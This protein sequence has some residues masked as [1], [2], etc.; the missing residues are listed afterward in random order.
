MELN[1]IDIKQLH[2][3][4][5]IAEEGSITKAAE[6]IHMAQ[7]PL[8]KQLKMLE[9]EL[10]VEL[11]ERNT[12]NLKITEAGKHLHYRAQ[13]I[14]DL[15]ETT[16]RELKDYDEGIYGTLT[17]GTIS[18]AGDTL[19]PEKVL[20][21]HKKYPNIRFH[22]KKNNTH[23]VLDLLKNGLIDVGI[24][25]TPIDSEYYDSI[26]FPEEPMVAATVGTPFWTDSQQA[27]TIADLEGKPLLILNRYKETVVKACHNA[28]FEP[29]IIGKIDDTR[30]IMLWANK[31]MGVAIVQRDWPDLMG[32][33]D[34][35]Y[36]EIAE[37]LL[38]TQPAVVWMKNRYLS[39]VTRHF[40]ES[41]TTE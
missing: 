38:L 17:V 29:H 33:N 39:S 5:A 20:S 11:F 31:G 2:Y 10:Q 28:G 8:S 9:E 7:P 23:E 16:V 35:V 41:F 18:S 3:F 24:V 26:L 32:S 19:L 21:F 30:T 13:Q 22:I 1:I 14:I 12:R 37:P 36:K 27:I 34:L 40:L 6:R 15:T 25:R 4:L